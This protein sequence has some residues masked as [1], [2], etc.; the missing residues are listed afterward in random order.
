MKKL[1][2]ERLFENVMGNIERDL[3]RGYI[4]GASVL[5]AQGDEILLRDMR[6]VSDVDT[7]APLGNDAIFR[8]ASMTKP[9][10]GMAALIGIERGWFS[11][12]DKITKYFPEFADMFVGRLEGGRVVPDHKP[13]HELLLGQFLRN[14]TGFM[15]SSPIYAA[16]EDRIPTE[17]Y[18]DNATIVDY[19]IKNTCF[20]YEPREQ[21]GYCGYQ[22]Y[23]VVALLLERF[24][25]MKYADFVRENIFNPLGIT[26]ITYH[27]T[28][29]QWGRV[30]KMSDRAV[31][32]MV[33]VNMG[34]HTFEQFPLSYTSAGAGLVG[35]VEDYYKFARLLR[36]RGTADG[37]R[38]VGE[39]V[40]SLMPKPYLPL[41][42]MGEGATGSWGLGVYVRCEGDRL[43]AGSFGWSGAYGTHFFVDPKND[44][45]A[46]Y[47]K[48]TRW[49]DSHGG[50]ETGKAFESA[51]MASLI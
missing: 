22:A 46:I 15:G 35:T 39:D 10:A 49:Y 50:G 47:M 13:R 17:M 5:V 2:K 21:Y 40:F 27:P 14:D 20:T 42:I 24:S 3:S 19:C 25:G 7:G 34:R 8:L 16:V 45:V 32:G 26:D 1:S 48:N 43:P 9:V 44:I 36:G 6:G 37:V 51:V 31:G 11:P 4:A 33:S 12:D 18:R 30:V 29:E 23:D 28:E 38:I 41:S